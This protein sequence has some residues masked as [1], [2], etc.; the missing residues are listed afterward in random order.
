MSF[1]TSTRF[2]LRRLFVA[3]TAASTCAAFAPSAAIAGTSTPAIMASTVQAALSCTS[4]AVEGVCFFLH[5]TLKGCWIRTSIKISHYVPDVVV[6]T[7]NDPL[8]HPWADLGTVVATSLTAAGSALTG[9]LLDS[10]AGGLDSTSAMANFKGADAIGNPAGM[11]ASMLASGGTLSMPTRVAFPSVGEISRFPSQELPNIG[12]QWAN[13]PASIAETVASDAKKFLSSDSLLASLGTILKTIEG[14]K[15]VMEI[16]ETVQQIQAGIAGLEQLS[17][18]VSG[19][20]GGTSLF[21]PGGASLFN[22]H[23]QSELDAPF[24]R[25]VIPVEMLYPQ[26]WIPGLAEVGSGYTQTWGSVF[27]RTGEIIQVHPVKASAVLAER[28]A[29]IIYRSAQPH[30]YSRVVPSGGYYYFGYGEHHKWQMLYPSSWSNCVE[31]GQNDSLSLTSFGDGQT[32]S[33]DGYAWNLWQRYTCC[34]RRGAFLYSV[35]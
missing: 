13:V 10:S 6:S 34:R 4:Y 24:W 7:Y 22:L 3:L 28:V 23:F 19:A 31:F 33:D 1:L 26:S 21:C 14:V 35:P 17:S 12:R 30:I 29:S 9:H 5:C 8:R 15:Q 27:P 25:G 20:T 32:S 2:K 18:I 16:A 11:F